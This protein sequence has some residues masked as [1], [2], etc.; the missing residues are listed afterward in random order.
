MHEYDV[1]REN[2]LVAD[3]NAF[4]LP[5][6]KHR[7]QV[8]ARM[9]RRQFLSIIIVNIY[10]WCEAMVI[11]PL[12]YASEIDIDRSRIEELVWS[13]VAVRFLYVSCDVE[14]IK[15]KHKRYFFGCRQNP[16]SEEE[17]HESPRCSK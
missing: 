1:L 2:A 17:R 8:V 5:I 3:E 9:F 4:V 10:M 6:K 11:T 14:D 15:H 12:I 7:Q 16:P 13:I